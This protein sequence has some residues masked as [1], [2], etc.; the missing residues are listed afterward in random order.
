MR[1]VLES[2]KGRQSSIYH[3]NP[4]Y[5][6]GSWHDWANIEWPE[7]P[8][9]D[10]DAVKRPSP[11]PARLLVF[12]R[13]DALSPE[14]KDILSP[15]VLDDGKG[16]SPVFLCEGTW[17]VALQSVVENIYAVPPLQSKYKTYLAHEAQSMVYWADLETEKLQQQ[18][19]ATIVRIAPVSSIHSTRIA[20]PFDITES[21]PIRWLLVE[22][23]GDWLDM[24]NDVM[25]QTIENHKQERKERKQLAAN[26]RNRL[27]AE[28]R[29]GLAAALRKRP[30]AELLGKTSTGHN[31]RKKR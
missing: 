17:Y 16:S 22:S 20:V 23:R 24:L 31:R 13:I 1:S 28:E 10:V 15:V 2:S 29:N 8:P 26:E 25:K 19:M 18:E 12:F 5:K 27:A 21:F 14:Y 6:D 11:L 30:P 9:V 4:N 3:A 7:W